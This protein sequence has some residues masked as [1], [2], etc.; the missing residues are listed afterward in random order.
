MNATSM[1]NKFELVT[2]PKA[3]EF[4]FFPNFY[5]KSYLFYMQQFLF[6]NFLKFQFNEKKKQFLV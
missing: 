6:Q 5:G 4:R 2:C 1:S 3:R